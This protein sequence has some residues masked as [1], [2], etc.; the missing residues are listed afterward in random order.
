MKFTDT[1]WCSSLTTGFVSVAPEGIFSYRMSKPIK[2]RVGTK[3]ETGS[4]W[5]LIKW[6]RTGCSSVGRC[7]AID[8][9]GAG[10]G[11]GYV[12]LQGMAKQATICGSTQ[13]LRGI[14][15]VP[16]C[17]L[18]S[19]VRSSL[20]WWLVWDGALPRARLPRLPCPAGQLLAF[21][22]GFAGCLRSRSGFSTG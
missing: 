10:S 6:S 8:L 7:F 21:P 16:Q 3:T 13:P 11:M 20:L 2:H 1:I 4:C 18:L 14:W 17:R 19:L 22:G 9:K 5:Y 12:L 15:K